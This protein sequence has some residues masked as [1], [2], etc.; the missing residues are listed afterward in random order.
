MLHIS[1]FYKKLYGFTFIFLSGQ[2]ANIIVQHNWYL[3]ENLM[4]GRYSFNGMNPNIEEIMKSY[5]NFGE[6]EDQKPNLED[7]DVDISAQRFVRNIKRNKS[8][9]KNVQEFLEEQNEMR[10]CDSSLV[11]TMASK[12]IKGQKRKKSDEIG[13]E[14]QG[15]QKKTKFLKPEPE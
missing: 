2:D 8:K 4:L 3:T 9:K 6:S 7:M 15:G 5:C 10:N 12:F 13:E 11:Q 14:Q 1:D